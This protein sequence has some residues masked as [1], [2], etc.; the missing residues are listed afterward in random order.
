MPVW[1]GEWLKWGADM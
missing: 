1:W